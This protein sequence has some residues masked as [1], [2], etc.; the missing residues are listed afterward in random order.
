MNGLNY[1]KD[2]CFFVFNVNSF[3]R[4]LFHD[5]FKY[6]KL[7]HLNFIKSVLKQINFL[8]GNIYF[9]FVT[10]DKF[11]YLLYNYLSNIQKFIDNSVVLEYVCYKFN[12][13]L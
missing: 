3:N 9:F 2:G 10:G 12:F 5:F 6:G 7:F 1:M 4:Y 11:L 8:S 13:T